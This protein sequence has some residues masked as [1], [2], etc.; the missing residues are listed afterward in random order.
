MLQSDKN[1]QWTQFSCVYSFHQ[2]W[3]NDKNIHT[4]L[5]RKFSLQVNVGYVW[6]I[7][8]VYVSSR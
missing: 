6:L 7:K 3:K 2:K 4:A 8:I 5:Y 1:L